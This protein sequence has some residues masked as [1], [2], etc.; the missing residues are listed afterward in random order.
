METANILKQTSEADISVEKTKLAV[1]K[2]NFPKL[3]AQIKERLEKQDSTA[4]TGRTAYEFHISDLDG[5]FYV[6]ISDG[7]IDV[8][9]YDYRDHD[10]VFT[11]SA[12]TY[13]ALCD[14]SLTPITAYAV[15]RLKISGRMDQVK[16]L[17]KIFA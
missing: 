16:T 10:G 4:L 9:P 6:E 12:A 3:F 14:G 15:G 1:E 5:V 13:E 2:K 17:M 8:Q 11:A 7:R